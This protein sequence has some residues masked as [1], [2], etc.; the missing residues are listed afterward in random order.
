MAATAH[1]SE[2]DAAQATES[3]AEQGP[4]DAAWLG[5]VT[6]VVDWGVDRGQ[7]FGSLF[8]AVDAQNRVI[9]GAGLLGAYNT[10]DRSDR[11]QLQVFVRLPATAGLDPEPLP[12]P[13]DDAGHYLFGFDNRLFANT[14]GGRNDPAL[15]V[16][17]SAENAWDEDAET[18]PFSV[19][20]ADGVLAATRDE[21][22]FDDRPLVRAAEEGGELA[23]MYFGAG[24]LVWRRR[25][26][27]AEPAVN[28]LVA[29]PWT[30]D[31]DR[32]DLAT[33]QRLTLPTPREFVYAYGQL[34][35]QVVAVTN[36]GGVF[37]LDPAGWRAWRV[38]DG[39]SYQV[40]AALNVRRTVLLGHYPSGELLEFAR[41][42]LRRLTGWPPAMPGVRAQ[43]REAQSLAIYGGDLYVGIWPWGEVWRCNLELG[44]W[45]FLGRLFSQPEPTSET[46]HP[47]ERET[48]A[49]DP[50]LNRWGQRVTSLVPEGDS[51]YL[52]TSAKSSAPHEEEFAFLGEVGRQEYGAI[53]RHRRPGALAVGWKWTSAPTT[54]EIR[55]STTRLEVWQDDRLLGSTTWAPEEGLP[56]AP[57]QVRL[58]RGVF[59][60]FAGRELRQANPLESRPAPVLAT[61]LDLSRGYE[62]LDSPAE[63]ARKLEALATRLRASGLSTVMP[64]ANTSSGRVYYP[65]RVVSRH[66][67]DEGDPLGEFLTAAHRAGLEVW[68]AVCVNASGHFEPVGILEEH[69]EWA[70]RQESGA[71]WGF[72]SPAHPEARAWIAAWLAELVERHRPEGLL[73]DYLRYFNRPWRFDAAAEDQLAADA[74]A[75]G[76]S[77]AA[78]LEAFRQ[79]R[80]EHYLTQLLEEIR[81]AVRAV[82]PRVRLGIYTWG[83][84][85]TRN[86]RVAQPWP[87]WAAAGLIDLV[88]VSGYYYREQN[89]PEYRALYRRRLSE[90]RELA[91]AAPHPLPVTV[92][93]GVHTS[94]GSLDSAELIDQ[95][96]EDAAAAGV[97]GAAWFTWA[98]SEPF[99][100]EL[101]AR[102]SLPRFVRAIQ[103]ASAVTA[104]TKENP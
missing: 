23:E 49:L 2:V 72:L 41:R 28:E 65:S 21:L 60:D 82:D 35:D 100:A 42:E 96:L 104:A 84:H 36:T 78:A 22:R 31:Q 59:G 50:V 34:G 73:L 7:N 10:Q 44:E 75:A 4:E 101:Q 24:R 92:A 74:A 5:R 20:V 26:A 68:P 89:G 19:A 79:S 12:R 70:L 77:E 8:E 6:V 88:N 9:A 52:A 76:I 33:A 17:N 14:R 15:R 57:A 80:A 55:W 16:W 27:T 102:D 1:T 95:Y 98:A 99:W 51:L 3:A 64:Y 86:H 40:Y 90:A 47:Y 32:P 91:R 54:F 62:R 58:G 18:I 29:V 37:T 81:T 38:T 71:P 85:V 69:P 67:A 94:H 53:Y 61:Y 87:A 30:P 83:P 45:E 11:R 56:V 63:R 97:D 66:V 46:V 103:Q 93:L 48:A 25:E 39:T 43:A 13:T